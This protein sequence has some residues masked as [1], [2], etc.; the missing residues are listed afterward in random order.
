MFKVFF[1]ILK[2][3]LVMYIFKKES[4]LDFYLKIVNRSNLWFGQKSEAIFKIL[5]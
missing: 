3:L 4:A 2:Y 1:V 5:K